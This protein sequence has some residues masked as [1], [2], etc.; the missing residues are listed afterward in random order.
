MQNRVL[1]Q[2]DQQEYKV[3]QHVENLGTWVLENPLPELRILIYLE[4]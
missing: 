4:V 3:A 1:L 2:F